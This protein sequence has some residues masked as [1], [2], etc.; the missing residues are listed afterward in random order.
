M[1]QQALTPPPPTSPQSS[2]ATSNFRSLFSQALRDY[3]RRTGEDLL[4]HPL[5][6]K[7]KDCHSP[8]TILPVLE[9]QTRALDQRRSGDGT[10]TQFQWLRSTVVVLYHLSKGIEDRA[11]LV[12]I[13]LCS[14]KRCDSP[15]FFQLL[16]P[17]KV[18]FVGIGVLLSVSTLLDFCAWTAVKPKSFG[19]FRPVMPARSP[20]LTPLE[21]WTLS[22]NDSHFTSRSR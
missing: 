6:S 21:G 11:D 14:F 19:P 9:E 3:K 10:S 22:S 4:L 8:D 18:I 2:S 17:A 5:A 15:F 1:A 7:L 20:L 13:R 12:V 16:S